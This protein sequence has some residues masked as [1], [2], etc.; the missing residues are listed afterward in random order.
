[1]TSKEMRTN[2]LFIRTGFKTDGR[3]QIPIIK[4]EK[5]DLNNISLIACSDTRLNDNENNKKNG[6]HF[7]VDDYR[8]KGIYDNPE[9]TYKRYSQYSFLLTPDFSVY[10]DMDTWQQIENVAHKQWIGAYWQSKG[11]TV[12]PTVSWGLAQSFEFCFA[13]I[14]KGSIVAV[15]M[16]GCKMA[17]VNFLCGYNAMLEKLSPEKI[18][19]F[20]KPFEEMKGD[21]IEIDYMKSRKVVR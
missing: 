10:A 2:N 21:I 17:K 5:I 18:I 14:E 15:G 13:G 16:I 9:R 11:I 4:K 6:V 7:F 8:F 1:M 3:L 20:G 19:C 12:I